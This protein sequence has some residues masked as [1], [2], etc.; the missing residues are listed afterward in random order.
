LSQNA[1]P[2]STVAPQFG[3][4]LAV[5]VGISEATAAGAAE[6]VAAAGSK[7]EPH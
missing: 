6:G 5:T 3:Q 1:S 7:R 2:G 4:L